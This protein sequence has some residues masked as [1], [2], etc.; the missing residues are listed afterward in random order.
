M[1]EFIADLIHRIQGRQELSPMAAP[2]STGRPRCGSRRQM[3]EI[4]VTP[5]VDVMLVLLIIS[6]LAAPMLQQGMHL[7]L[8]GADSSEDIEQSR[9]VVS[10]NREGRI[11]INDKPVHPEL[12]R[13]RMTG[14]A[15]TRP[16]ENVYLRADK[17]LNYGEVLFVMD[18]I[19]KAGIVNV[20]LVTVPLEEEL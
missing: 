10:V 12:L 6:M 1:D 8:P 20:T 16:D 9:V 5:L 7:E 4:N 13:E 19:R 15:A 2:R 18:T 11:R 3:A 14:L 17:L